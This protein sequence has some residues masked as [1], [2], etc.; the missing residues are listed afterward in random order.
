[1]AEQLGASQLLRAGF[2]EPREISKFFREITLGQLTT[3]IAGL[4]AK[5]ALQTSFS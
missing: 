4:Q 2:L 3:C 5:P 1:M